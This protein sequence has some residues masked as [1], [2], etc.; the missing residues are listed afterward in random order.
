[1]T[2]TRHTADTITDD[3]LDE[4][5]ERLRKA[6]R[7]ANLLADA[8]RRADEPEGQSPAPPHPH[9][10]E[11]WS[12]L[13]WTFWGS[14]M[15]DV[16]REP[17]AD[18]M[19]AAITPEQRQQAEALMDQWHASGRQ[20]LG[21]RRY[22]ELSGELTATQTAIDRAQQVCHTLPYEHARQILAA[23]DVEE[24]TTS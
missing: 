3:A 1:M 19:I 18:A 4:L 23:L 14:G 21:R 11:L 16:F 13:D 17:L 10:G 6:E 15:A 24:S 8:H 9:R 20:P 2:E 7:A 12:L 22:E 5:Y